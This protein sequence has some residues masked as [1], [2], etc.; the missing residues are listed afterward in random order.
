[1]SQIKITLNGEEKF[2]KNHQTLQDLIDDLELDLEKIAIEKD[3]EIIDPAQFSK[4]ILNE[5]SQIEIVHFI[6]GG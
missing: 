1:M 3:L 4:I 2:L 6:G 5:G